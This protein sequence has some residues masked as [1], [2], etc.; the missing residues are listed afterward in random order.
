MA[1][2][3]ERAQVE[4]KWSESAWAK[5]R[6]QRDRRRALSDFDRFK[7]M[8]LKKQVSAC[9]RGVVTRV[10]CSHILPGKPKS[11]R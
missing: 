5:K 6:E 4:K 8:R 10:V 9:F 1:R 3:W 7:V 2:A 11:G